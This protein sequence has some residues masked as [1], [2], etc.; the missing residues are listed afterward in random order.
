MDQRNLI[1][2]MTAGDLVLSVVVVGQADEIAGAPHP[3]M[4]FFEVVDVQ[5]PGVE[6]PDL[7]PAGGYVEVAFRDRETGEHFQVRM[8]AETPLLVTAISL[9]PMGGALK[10]CGCF[11]GP[12]S[13]EE[14]DRFVSIRCE[15]HRDVAP[16]EGAEL[17]YRGEKRIWRPP[18][19]RSQGPRMAIPKARK[20]K[21]ARR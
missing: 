10:E 4:R 15:K 14:Q 20:R 7:V 17:L 11:D 5:H 18:G 9:W 3:R 13:A 6:D 19:P 12:Y 21:R 2:P 8:R 16:L 1:H